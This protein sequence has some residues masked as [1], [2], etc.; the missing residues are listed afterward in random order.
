LW[1]WRRGEK[2]RPWRQQRSRGFHHVNTYSLRFFMPPYTQSC[3]SLING[4]LTRTSEMH[5]GTQRL[6][7][8]RANGPACT[9]MHAHELHTHAAAHLSTYPLSS[10]R[11]C[12]CCWI[13]SGNVATTILASTYTRSRRRPRRRTAPPRPN[14]RPARPT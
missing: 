11:S 6:L 14:P 1:R 9:C 13:S 3:I 12:T 2:R 10:H 7:H 4:S 8:A 5:M